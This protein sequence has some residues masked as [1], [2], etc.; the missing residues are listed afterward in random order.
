M[1]RLVGLLSAPTSG[2]YDN[3]KLQRRLTLRFHERIFH[4]TTGDSSFQ[5]ET[6][7]GTT[8]IELLSGRSIN[9]SITPCCSGTTYRHQQPCGVLTLCSGDEKEQC[10]RQQRRRPAV[11]GHPRAGAPL[12]QRH[13]P[14]TI[15]HSPHSLTPAAQLSTL[16]HCLSP[17]ASQRSNHTQRWRSRTTRH[18]PALLGRHC[19][20]ARPRT[21]G[22]RCGAEAADAPPAPLGDGARGDESSAGWR[23]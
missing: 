9:K 8:P 20:T 5:Q 15:T 1:I 7:I 14:A 21:A 18:R 12:G 11:T 22:R 19:S 23:R 13:H 17:A 2:L 4:L 3:E 10:R 16:A 6:L